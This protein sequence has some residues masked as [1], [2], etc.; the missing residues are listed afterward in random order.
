MVDAIV[1]NILAFSQRFGLFRLFVLFVFVFVLFNGLGLLGFVGP[2]LIKILIILVGVYFRGFVV[3]GK[4]E[5]I[6]AIEFMAFNVV[7]VAFL[8]VSQQLVDQVLIY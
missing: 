4:D 6:V 3:G 8:S 2:L 7:S 1:E 5:D